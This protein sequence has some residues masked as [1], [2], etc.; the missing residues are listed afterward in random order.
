MNQGLIPN[1]YAKALYK[2]ATENNQSERVY[3]LMGRL[4]EAFVGQ[5]QLQ[6]VVKN[7]YVAIEDKTALLLT[8]AGAQSVDTCYVDFLKLLVDKKRIDFIR[9]IALAYLDIYRKDNNI[10][11]VDIVTAAPL[12]QHEL[13]KLHNLVERHIPEATIEFAH[14][15]DADLIGGFV[16]NINSERLDASVSNELKQLRL[17]LLS[18]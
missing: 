7:P 5:P 11:Q 13:D 1:R 12:A 15:V 17:K 10:Y 2:F 6:D 8:A 9:G 16:I 3:A 18:N 4:V 14:S